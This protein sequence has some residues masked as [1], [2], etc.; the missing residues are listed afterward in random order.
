MAKVYLR[1]SDVESTQ[2]RQRARLCGIANETYVQHCQESG[3]TV[4]P[5]DGTMYNFTVK[6]QMSAV[7]D[8]NGDPV[9]DEH[10]MPTYAGTG[11]FCLEVDTT[12]AEYSSLPIVHVNRLVDRA[13]M[14]TEG[15]FYEE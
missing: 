11:E 14:E 6:Q 15:W 4:V 12:Q 9:L 5:K 7:L 8:E 1:G 13:T 2:T 3:Y 10:D